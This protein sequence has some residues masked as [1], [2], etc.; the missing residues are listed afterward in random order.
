MST[1]Q[2]YISATGQMVPG[3]LPLDEADQI[4]AIEMAME[5]HSRH[6]PRLIVEDFDGD[7]GFDYALADFASW[8][9]GFSVI[10]SVEYPVDDDDETPDM[11]EDADWMIYETPSGKFLRFLSDVPSSSEDFRVNYTAMHTCT[12]T[13]CTVEDADEKAVQTLAAGMFCELLATHHAQQGDSS[14]DA[15]VVDHKSKSD[16]YSRRAGRYRK[17]YFDHLGMKE[18]QT[19]AAS[20]TRDWDLPASHGGDYLTHPKRY[21]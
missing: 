5:I 7:G 13:A 11:L 3:D 17:F 16:E 8:S 19:P 9:D 18:G 21:R 1:R 2:D 6:R 14:I 15:D 4:L 10:K 20:V 12:D